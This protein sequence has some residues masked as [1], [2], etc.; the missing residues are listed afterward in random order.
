MFLQMKNKDKYFLQRRYSRF[1]S[2]LK[3]SY[4]K[5]GQTFNVAFGYRPLGKKSYLHLLFNV[6]TYQ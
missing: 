5:R 2:R 4:D 1:E 3:H 6:A